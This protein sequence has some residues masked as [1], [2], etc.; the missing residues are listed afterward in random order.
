MKA[1]VEDYVARLTSRRRDTSTR[2]QL[3]LFV[4]RY[5]RCQVATGVNGVAE[6]F[7]CMALTYF[8]S[9]QAADDASKYFQGM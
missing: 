6:Y 2:I 8:D 9:A 5:F 3:G 7:D 1:Y 4:V